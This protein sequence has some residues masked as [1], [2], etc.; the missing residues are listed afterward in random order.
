MKI[1][2]LLAISLPL[3]SWEPAQG[4]QLVAAKAHSLMEAKYVI[5]GK[6]KS[7]TFNQSKFMGLMEVSIIEILKGKTELKTLSFPVD[8]NSLNG[9]DAL[10]KEG[11]IAVFFVREVKDGKA[12][13]VAPGASAT[14]SKTYVQ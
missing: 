3:L 9:F 11:D 13:L 1:I 2:F 12:Y 10:L 14:F 6:V 7:N 8:M 5:L 4:S